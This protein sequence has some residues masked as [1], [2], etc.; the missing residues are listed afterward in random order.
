MTLEE[1]NIVMSACLLS[2]WKDK[3]KAIQILE[4]E[5]RLKTMD[6]RKD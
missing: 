3:K 4:R 5:I 6:P 1:L 2:G